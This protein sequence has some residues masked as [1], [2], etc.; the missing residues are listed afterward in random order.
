MRVIPKT[1]LEWVL[2]V[3]AAATGVIIS[4]ASQDF[5]IDSRHN[6]RIRA[7]QDVAAPSLRSLIQSFR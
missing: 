5:F 3:V 6:P 7:L 4:V 1:P 2:L